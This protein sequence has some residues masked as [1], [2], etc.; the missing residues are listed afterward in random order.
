MKQ[1]KSLGDFLSEKRLKKTSQRFLV[2]DTL[3]EA[4]DH[5]SVEQIRERLLEK[6][7]RIGL[8]TIYRTLKILLESG[9][10]RQ[11]KLDGTTRYELLVNQPNHIHFV[12]NRCGKNQE[13]PSSRIERLIRE[14]TEKNDFQ[15]V[16]SRYAIFGF[17]RECAATEAH[18]SGIEGRQREQKILARDALELTLAVE[19]RG[20][21]FYMNASKR[22]RDPSGKKMFR[23]LA[24]EESEHMN[25]LQQEYRK[26][27]Q[28]HGWLRR[29]PARLPASRKIADEI[30]PE[31]ELLSVDVQDGT[32]HLEA[33][34]LAIDLERKSH[35]FFNDFAK[36]LDDPHGQKIFREFADEERLHL[37]GLQNEHRKLKKRNGADS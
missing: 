19:R 35:R 4:E 13:F 25:K 12:C 17:C 29:E 31:R 3:L 32:T 28:E 14:E 2:W 26:L 5:P 37:E 1:K 21:S 10:I 34:E 27:I 20:Y 24:E 30:F 11:A 22:T 7:H 16:Y 9:M 36:Q 6:G 8:S 33:L 15:P 18:Q 23:D